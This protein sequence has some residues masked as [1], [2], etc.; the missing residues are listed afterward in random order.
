MLEFLPQKIKNGLRYVNLQHVYELRL[1]VDKPVT[2]SWKGDYRY[3][4]EYGLTGNRQKAL[5]IGR[6]HV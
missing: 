4:S 6:A 2:V 3:L 5:E 1:R